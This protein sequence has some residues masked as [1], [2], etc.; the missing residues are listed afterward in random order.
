MTGRIEAIRTRCLRSGVGGRDKIHLIAWEK[1]L[2]SLDLEAWARAL[3]STSNRRIRKEEIRVKKK[4]NR[5]L[6]KGR[7]DKG[8]NTNKSEKGSKE[9]T[10][11]D[12]V[13]IGDK[14]WKKINMFSRMNR[15]TP[16]MTTHQ[17]NNRQSRQRQ[18]L[19]LLSSRPIQE[20][21]TLRAENPSHF[22]HIGNDD[23]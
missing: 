15:F 3:A 1:D 14:I 22:R 4:G 9:G 6:H 20:N 7:E 8:G 21:L 17:D 10:H 19:M 16:S 13:T 12:R 11:L 18:A 23:G 2:Q 5:I